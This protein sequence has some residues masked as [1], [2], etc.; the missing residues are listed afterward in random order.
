M[1]GDCRGDREWYESCGD[2]G[3]V[4]VT[5]SGMS[6]VVDSCGGRG[7]VVVTESGMSRVVDSCGDRELVVVIGS[8]M[9]MWWTRVVVGGLSW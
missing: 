1:L 3:L 9:M 4:V 7:L 6:R 2:M 8:G 5:G